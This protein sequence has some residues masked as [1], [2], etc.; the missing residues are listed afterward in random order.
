MKA[1]TL[2]MPDATSPPLP[3]PRRRALLGAAALLPAL[4]MGRQAAAQAASTPLTNDLM[5]AARKEGTVSFYTTDDDVLSDQLAKGFE[6]ANPGIKVAMVRAS[7]E[8]LAKRITDEQKAGR[9]Q[10]DVMTTNDLR[11]LVLARRSGWLVPYVPEQVM[12]WPDAARDP[13]GFYTIQN[14]ALMVIGFNN[15]MVVAEQA[16]KSYE[17]LLTR[18]WHA[19]LVKVNPSDSGAGMA[20]TFVL[21][22]DL[23]WGFWERLAQQNVL[24]VRTGAEA[25]AKLV[26]SDRWAMVDGTE[27]AALRLRAS[28]A[29]I[30]IVHAKEGTPVAPSGTALF[31]E[32]PHPNAGRVFVNWLMG[33]EAQQ[34]VVSSGARSYHPDIRDTIERPPLVNLKLLVA[35]PILLAAESELIKQIFDQFFPN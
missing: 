6:A 11:S 25:P 10:A 19:K 4:A 14:I 15:K 9:W 33:R 30:S 13:A 29:P 22:R 18:R 26:N 31:K 17:D 16:P 7:A 34:I 35:D 21:N 20:S 1:R 27:Q 3:I 24:Q 12:R 23:G 2:T 5:D 32:A 28:G 8:T